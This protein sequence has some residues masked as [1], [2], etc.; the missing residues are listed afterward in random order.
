MFPETPDSVLTTLGSMSCLVRFDRESIS[1]NHLNGHT[2]TGYD[3]RGDSRGEAGRSLVRIMKSC[4]WH[5]RRAEG[6]TV[7]TRYGLLLDLYGDHARRTVIL[8]LAFSR[9]RCGYLGCEYAR[10]D[11]LYRDMAVLHHHGMLFNSTD[12][13]GHAL[14]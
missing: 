2:R 13:M 3:Y 14:T 8:R 9:C 12:D 7:G 1:D 10:I 4:I 11:L 6:R 5:R